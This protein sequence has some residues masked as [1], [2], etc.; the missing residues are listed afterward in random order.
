MMS[1]VDEFE[2]YIAELATALGHADREVPLRG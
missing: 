2:A 1:E